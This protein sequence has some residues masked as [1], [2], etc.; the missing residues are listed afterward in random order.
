MTYRFVDS[1]TDS[2]RQVLE[3]TYRQAEK[4]A[5][6]RRAHAI[7]LSHQRYTIDQISDILGATRETV[8]LCVNL[9]LSQ[10]ILR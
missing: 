10:L 5:L 8:S 6:R 9:S 7:L 2:D 3:D 4:P 1:L